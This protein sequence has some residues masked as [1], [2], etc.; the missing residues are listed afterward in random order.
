MLPGWSEFEAVFGTAYDQWD[1]GTGRLGRDGLIHVAHHPAPPVE[2]T[3]EEK[4]EAYAGVRIARS[5]LD[6]IRRHS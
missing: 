6:F 1:Y 5:A 4:D 2:A 3:P